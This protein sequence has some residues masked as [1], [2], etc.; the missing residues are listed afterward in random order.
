VEELQRVYRLLTEED[1]QRYGEEF[2]EYIQGNAGQY[3]YNSEDHLDKIGKLIQKL[4]E[5]LK[6]KY[7][8]E[9]F[10]QVMKKGI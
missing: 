6:P 4:L 5:E 9:P 2:I 8:P 7:E 3:L 10:Y 1:Q